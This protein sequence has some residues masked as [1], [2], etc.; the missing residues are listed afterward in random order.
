MAIDSNIN[1]MTGCSTS[2]MAEEHTE[3]LLE[4]RITN[5]EVRIRTGQ[6]IMD[7]ILIER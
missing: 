6:Q 5:F 2:Q 4:D 7:N 3:H 1:K